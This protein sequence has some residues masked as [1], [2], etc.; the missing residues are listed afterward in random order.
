MADDKAKE[1]DEKEEEERNK[2]NDKNFLKWEIRNEKWEIAARWEFL[3]F[4]PDVI[5]NEYE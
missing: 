5:G 3:T 2:N 4:T 1:R